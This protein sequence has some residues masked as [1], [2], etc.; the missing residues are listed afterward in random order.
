M[1]PEQTGRGEGEAFLTLILDQLRA[2]GAPAA[3]RLTVAD[4]NERAIRLYRK[5]GFRETASFTRND[6]RFLVLVKKEI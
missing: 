5:A 2:T 4:F 6:T 3:L 1:K